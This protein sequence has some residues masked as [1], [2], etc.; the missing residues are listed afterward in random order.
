M[1]LLALLTSIL[2]IAASAQDVQTLL[3]E[4]QRDYI[5]GDR[6]AAKEKF[7]I[8]QKAEPNNR[9]AANYLRMIAA[10]EKK[11]GVDETAGLRTRMEK[12]VI[13]RIDFR[14]ATVGEALEF[15]G[16][17]VAAAN[18]N[19]DKVNI[20]QQLT[21]EQKGA[22]ITLSLNNIAASEALRY[23]TELANLS[24]SYEKFAVVVKPKA[25]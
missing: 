23:V 7:T 17:K 1:K 14:D 22:R 11:Q 21:D 6:A 3:T 4:A 16:K 9:I 19:A 20:V 5:R 18:P 24:V 15:L 13:D 12:T 8:I 2:T 25:K 10:E